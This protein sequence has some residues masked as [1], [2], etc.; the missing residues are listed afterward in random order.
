MNLAYL[1][2]HSY[3]SL[4]ESLLSPEDLALTAQEFDIHAGVDRLPVPDWRY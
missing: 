4:L 3:Y 2:T 1:R